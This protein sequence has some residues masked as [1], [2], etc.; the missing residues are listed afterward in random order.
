M[1]FTLVF[2]SHESTDVSVG[3]VF[4]PCPVWL[5]GGQE[6]LNAHPRN[7]HYMSGDLQH[8]L[9]ISELRPLISRKESIKAVVICHPAGH[10]TEEYLNLLLDDLCKERFDPQVVR[11]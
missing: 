9:D 10:G 11:L 7:P 5:L 4:T 1:K 6:L 3:L 8:M 2:P